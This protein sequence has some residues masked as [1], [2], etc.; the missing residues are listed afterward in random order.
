MK[1]SLMHALFIAVKVSGFLNAAGQL[2]NYRL[3]TSIFRTRLW[4][5][6]DEKEFQWWIWREHLT[7]PRI[8]FYWCCLLYMPKFRGDQSGW[9]N[10]CFLSSFYKIHIDLKV[11]HNINDGFIPY[12]AG[13]FS[14]VFETTNSRWVENNV[15][16]II[17]SSFVM[18]ARTQE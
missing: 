9:K 3:R 11:T 10:I 5:V 14:E 7:S 17:Y 15:L 6:L 2:L 4:W 1:C 18:A 8:I 13:V 12:W 16:K